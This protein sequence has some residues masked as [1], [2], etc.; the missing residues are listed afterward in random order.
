[1]Q[2]IVPVTSAAAYSS[3]TDF[4]AGAT[5]SGNTVEFTAEMLEE[6]PTNLEAKLAEHVRGT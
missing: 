2:F 6:S 1:M 3:A 5:V 4:K